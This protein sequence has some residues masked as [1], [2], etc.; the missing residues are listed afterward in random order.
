MS[1]VSI[2]KYGWPLIQAVAP[3]EAWHWY[4]HF[5]II[6]EATQDTKYMCFTDDDKRVIWR[7]TKNA[8]VTTLE[9]SYGEWTDKANL[10]YAPINGSLEVDV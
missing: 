6:D 4:E 1:K 3:E 8:D 7:E 5:Y 2:N 10:T 9:F